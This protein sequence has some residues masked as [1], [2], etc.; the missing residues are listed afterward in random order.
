MSGT[1]IASTL[2]TFSGEG[3]PGSVITFMDDASVSKQIVMS[4]SGKRLLMADSAVVVSDN[5]H[6][7]GQVVV[8]ADGKWRFT[9]N[10]PLAEGSHHI[11]MVA[12]NSAGHRS[13]VSEL[14]KFEV[15]IT[16]PEKPSISLDVIIR[17][18]VAPLDMTQNNQDPENDN[19]WFIGKGEPGSTITITDNGIVIGQTLVDAS[20][21]WKYI[22]Q[23]ALGGGEHNA[24]AT[25]TDKAGNISEPSDTISFK[26]SD[27]NFEPQIPTIIEKLVDDVG[28]ITGEIGLNGVTDDARP[29]IVGQAK[30]GSIVN[31]YDA[32]ELLGSTVVGADGNWCFTPAMDLGQGEHNIIVVATDSKGNV[33]FSAPLLFTF[34]VDTTPPD[35]P[36]IES[37][38]ADFRSGMSSGTATNDVTPELNGVAEKGNLVTVLD[39]GVILGSVKADS[40]TGKWSFT[41]SFDLDFGDHIFTV[42]SMDVAGNQSFQSLGFVVVIDADIC[43]MPPPVEPVD[44]VA[45]AIPTIESAVDNMG[46]IQGLLSSGS[47]TDDSTPTLTGKADIGSIVKVYDGSVLLGSVAVDS[48]SG[49][50][51]FTPVAYLTR[52][53]H[54]FHVTAMD[55]AG[56]H[57]QLSESF[58]LIIEYNQYNNVNLTITNVHS[59]GPAEVMNN[60]P[61]YT[62]DIENGGAISYGKPL[63]SGTGTAGDVIVLYSNGHYDHV[64]LGRTTVDTNGKWS[65]QLINSLQLDD[66]ELFVVG[67]DAQGNVTGTSAPYAVTYYGIWLDTETPELVL[68]DGNQVF[69]PE[70]PDTTPP[71]SV[72]D[73]T[74]STK[75]GEYNNLTGYSD[76]PFFIDEY[77]SLVFKGKAEAGSIVS[78]YDGTTKLGESKVGADGSWIFVPSEVP[79]AGSHLFTTTVTDSAGNTSVKSNAIGLTLLVVAHIE[80]DLVGQMINIFAVNDINSQL[81]SSDYLVNDARPTLFGTT[82][83]TGNVITIYDGET[84]LGETYLQAGNK[85][86]FTPDFDLS[87]G[88]H[89]ITAFQKDAIRDVMLHSQVF[90]FVV[91]TIAPIVPTIEF[92]LDGVG[93]V[94]NALIS[95]SLTDDSTPTLT[96]HAE[97]GSTVKVYDG[98]TLLGLVT[99]DV[100]TGQWSFTPRLYKESHQFTVVSIDKAGNISAPSAA[101][102]LMTDFSSSHVN[103]LAITSVD[104]RKGDVTGHVINGDSS[105]DSRPIISGTGTAGDNVIVYSNDATGN[106][107]VGHT[108]VEADGTWGLQSTLLMDGSNQLTAVEV[109]ALGDIS[110]PSAPYIAVLDADVA[111]TY[112][113]GSLN[114]DIFL[115]AGPEDQV[116]AG[117][118]NDI[119]NLLPAK[120]GYISGGEGIDTL[121]VG[122][123][124]N[125]LNLGALEEKLSSVEIFDLKDGGHN[126]MIVHLEDVLRLGSEELSIAGNNKAIVVNG[127]DSSTLHFEMRSAQTWDGNEGNPIGK[128]DQPWVMSQNEHQYA[129]NTYNVWTNS[130]SNV[131]VLVENT[132]HVMM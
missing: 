73:M 7:I 99:A 121:V 105:D 81:L 114:D 27:S 119:I 78:V 44:T 22:P 33:N 61:R 128:A 62:G 13:S 83:G 108:T 12:T 14:M 86:S 122:G 6:V 21:R 60:G 111:P 39:N 93:L 10:S 56:N 87:Q 4:S 117:A 76:E 58:S 1:T 16:A 29:Q 48:Q 25:A 26:V 38:S 97:K 72:V 77:N 113:V 50:W 90:E 49:G 91:D 23:S 46:V 74:I 37:V 89:R 35:M 101:F 120:S 123:Y 24:Y 127:D 96:G 107:E 63:I 94:Q 70:V 79:M 75:Y 2:P 85:W 132:V 126:T 11:T 3:E 80:P 88:V 53:E 54:Q 92:A 30:I 71:N 130:A 31:I 59:D 34:V 67:I 43:I 8:G 129:G 57:S 102:V 64:E 15:D 98:G 55:S 109:N 65:L 9:P 52:G 32:D 110:A 5:S 19:L 84:L 118:G 116:I 51:S 18:D 20:G 106:H 28:S 95:G 82:V 66:N 36:V 125:L 47:I 103:N 68:E 115:Y 131:E 104:D 100:E 41:P 124:N 42:V 45:P 17:A 112:K 40:I 69:A